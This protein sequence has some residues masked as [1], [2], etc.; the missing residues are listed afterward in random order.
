MENEMIESLLNEIFQKKDG[1]KAAACTK[2]KE[3]GTA[4]I[5]RP[6][7]QRSK[8]LLHAPDIKNYYRQ[9][10]SNDDVDVFD[11]MREYMQ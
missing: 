5:N 9:P 2:G 3:T 1:N 6:N 8:N 7:Y 4:E 10:N 11:M